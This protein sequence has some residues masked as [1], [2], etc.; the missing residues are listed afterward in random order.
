MRD[1]MLAQRGTGGRVL[2]AMCGDRR[3]PHRG[4][5][6]PSSLGCLEFAQ[7]ALRTLLRHEADQIAYLPAA[8][9]ETTGYAAHTGAADARF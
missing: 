4:E 2:R 9:G 1:G 8:T 6:T 5:M 3:S 7:A